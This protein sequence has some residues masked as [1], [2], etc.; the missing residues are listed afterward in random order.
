MSCPRETCFVVK[1]QHGVY[2]PRALVQAHLDPILMF[3][4]IYCRQRRKAKARGAYGPYG[5]RSGQRD[6]DRDRNQNG[7]CS[8]DPDS[9]VHYVY[10]CYLQ[11]LVEVTF[12]HACSEGRPSNAVT[13]MGHRRSSKH[14]KTR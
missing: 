11:A 9:A 6:E 8:V 12:R 10:R 13:R 14:S 1:I 4:K 2:S 3:S 7:A 5:V